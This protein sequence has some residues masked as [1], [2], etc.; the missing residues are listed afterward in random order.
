MAAGN[1]TVVNSTTITAT[2]PAHSTGAV[3]VS[4]TNTDGQ[5]G[6]LA[7]AFTYLAPAP[8]VSTVTPSSGTTLG[9]TAVTISGSNFVAG[10]TVNLG[11]SLA[12]GATVVDS[13][14]ITATTPSHALGAVSVTVTNSDGQSGSLSG[15]FTY[16]AP[17]PA[18]KVTGVSPNNGITTGGTAVTITG[19]NFVAGATVSLPAQ[20]GR[21]SSSPAL[22]HSLRSPRPILPAR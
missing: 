11:G 20:P 5:T 6:S 13:A 1:V 14:S 17:V 8:T 21:T 18:P 2:T 10:A 16:I 3:T 22:P 4:V 15:G 9:G 7:G 19:A 12:S